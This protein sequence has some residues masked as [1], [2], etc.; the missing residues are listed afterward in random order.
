MTDNAPTTRE[1]QQRLREAAGLAASW[2]D[3][4]RGERM[5]PV[6]AL[7]A[8]R[9]VLGVPTLDDPDEPSGSP[10]SEEDAKR[11]F[12]AGIRLGQ[13]HPGANPEIEWV[14]VWGQYQQSVTNGDQA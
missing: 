8:I 10:I 14:S 1:P 13:R 9:D 6:F 3:E 12:M 2:L 7:Q 5:V 4:A 11:F